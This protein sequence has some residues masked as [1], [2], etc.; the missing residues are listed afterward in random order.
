MGLI[1]GTI[2]ELRLC[3]GNAS[4]RERARSPGG[5]AFFL[6]L[7]FRPRC[8]CCSRYL[9]AYVRATCLQVARALEP[10]GAAMHQ[11]H[12]SLQPPHLRVPLEKSLLEGAG[13]KNEQSPNE[14]NR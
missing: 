14:R 10:Y 9:R 5:C 11:P 3:V 8:T 1:E 7:F 13:V 4:S 2:T 12:L 6:Q